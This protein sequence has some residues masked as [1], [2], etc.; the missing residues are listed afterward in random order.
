MKLM[1]NM[2]FREIE[3]GKIV[4]S[5]YEPDEFFH[6]A[7]KSKQSKPLKNPMFINE[8][9]QDMD[10]LEPV[11]DGEE[12]LV[13]HMVD[14]N[15]HIGDGKITNE[16]VKDRY[17]GDIFPGLKNSLYPYLKRAYKYKQKVHID[18]YFYKN[19]E[20]KILVHSV[21]F[22][23]ND[24]IIVFYYPADK[25]AHLNNK[26]TLEYITEEEVV[27]KYATSIINMED[28]MVVLHDIKKGKH[29]LP[30]EIYTLLECEKKDSDTGNHCIIADYFIEEDYNKF[31]DLIHKINYDNPKFSINVKIVTPTGKLKSLMCSIFAIY[32][33]NK[34]L[35]KIFY[36]IK[37]VTQYDLT[38]G[39]VFDLNN[40]ILAIQ[41]LSRAAIYYLTLEGNYSWTSNIRD[42]IEDPTYNF[43]DERNIIKELIIDEDKP[44][45][46]EALK[47]ISQNNYVQNI[48]VRIKTLKGNIKELN[49]LIRYMYDGA[50]QVIS[51]SMHVYDISEGSVE[52]NYI[53]LA[54]AFSSVSSHLRTAIIYDNGNGLLKP[55]KVIEDI[56]GVSY[57]DWEK[58]GRKEFYNNIIDYDKL[59]EQTDRI[60]NHELKE[61]DKI[62]KYKYKGNPNDIRLFRY[63]LCRDDKLNIS[64]Y[65]EDIT[66][67]KENENN[68][69]RLNDEKSILIKEVHHRVK[70]NLQLLSSL[71]NLEEKFYHD[72]PERI[73]DST[74]KRL[75]SIA[76]MHEM[77]YSSMDLE[78][79]NLKQYFSLFNIEV[80]RLYYDKDIKIINNIQDDAYLPLSKITPLILIMNELISNS[81]KH[82]FNYTDTKKSN[83][84]TINIKIEDGYCILEYSDNGRGLPDDFDLDK[85]VALGWTI[86]KSFVQQLNGEAEQF[87]TDGFGLKVK[88]PIGD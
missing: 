40:S 23:E 21:I 5:D 15:R 38:T 42:I 18:Y 70:N 35:S 37:D 84:I 2:L 8:V 80:L 31:Y 69:I 26:D 30:D 41:T 24:E 16:D 71:L 53:R 4:I 78:T 48:K 59:K 50:G 22:Y 46:D 85:S 20:L 9:K 14:V 72:K 58:T 44:I 77:T 67:T 66:E 73:L 61:I 34:E 47:N 62:I 3:K 25:D 74:K 87:D 68:L 55:S 28:N 12:F 51:S 79:V 83:I 45:Y 64:G 39:R 76:L 88:F 57:N 75:K 52:I 17:Y 65:V 36:F 10:V 60:R 43:T 1:I 63:Y 56:A 19:K 27:E 7:K 11:D 33:D 6:H 49:V 54:N 82:A 13:K 86:I 32:D 81:I 29:V